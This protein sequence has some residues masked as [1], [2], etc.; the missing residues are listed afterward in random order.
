MGEEIMSA[1]SNMNHNLFM[2]FPDSRFSWQGLYTK[3]DTRGDIMILEI[4]DGELL[5]RGE[6]V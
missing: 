4:F 1:I 5:S 2:Q 3:F 6:I